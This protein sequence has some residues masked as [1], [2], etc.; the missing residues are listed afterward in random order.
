M[1]KLKK[2][3]VF[4]VAALGAIDFAPL[5]AAVYA[6]C[7][8]QAKECDGLRQTLIAGAQQL[9]QRFGVLAAA[10]TGGTVTVVDGTALVCA[11]LTQNAGAYAHA[12]QALVALVA[13]L[14]GEDAAC[15]YR[16]AL[17]HVGLAAR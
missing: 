12:V 15:T 6:A 1:K 9:E 13:T 10:L 17:Q 11:T 7:L 8:A 3:D 2:T 14:A 5:P 16:L 4:Y